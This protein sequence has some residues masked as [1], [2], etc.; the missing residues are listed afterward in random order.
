MGPAL[1]WV[2][3]IT[4]ASVILVGSTVLIGWALGNDALKGL[5]ADWVPMKANT[6]LAFVLAGLGLLLFRPPLS[7]RDSRR[8]TARM[9]TARIFTWLSGAIGLL[10]FAEHAFGWNAG[11]DQLIF[12]EPVGAVATSHPGRMSLDSAIC[13]V[14]LAVGVSIAQ[15]SRPSAKTR[16]ATAIAGAVISTIALGELFSYFSLTLRTESWGG[17]TQMAVDTAVLFTALGL[18]LLRVAVQVSAPES[19][20]PRSDEDRALDRGR[21]RILLVFVLLVVGIIAT[22]AAYYQN[23]ASRFRR[24]VEQQLYAVAELK[25]GE[26]K[27]WRT[28]RIAD[29]NILYRNPAITALVRRIF[30]GPD[31]ASARREL[32]MWLGKYGTYYRYDHIRLLDSAGVTRLSWPARIPSA[33]RVVVKQALEA[34]RSGQVAI[35]DFYRSDFDNTPRLAMLIPI[36]DEGARPRS[37]GV[38]VL[39]IDPSYYLYPLIKRWPT[40]SRTAE[41]LIV[42]REGNEVVFLNELR[43]QKNT[44]LAL[45]VPIDKRNI[46]LRFQ[47]DTALAL[48]VPMDKRNL[49]AVRAALGF[50]DVTTG[51]DYRGVAVIAAVHPVLDSPWSLVARMDESEAL[52]PLSAMFMQVAAAIG[53]LLLCAGVGLAV[54]SQR[55]QVRF[56][57]RQET[58]ADALRMEKATLDALFDSSPLALFVVDSGTNIVR[59]NLAA[60]TLTGSTASEMLHQRPGVALR[61]VHNT[62]D[63]RGC[64]YSHFCQLCPTRN[65]IERLI[66]SGG[67]MHGIEIPM[68]LIRDGTPQQVYLRTGAEAVMID[69]TR[70]LIIAMDDVTERALA[71]VQLRELTETLEERVTARTAALEA[72]N[73]EMEAFSYSVSH[74]LRAPLRS[75]DGFSRIVLADYQT[76]L[77]DEGRDSL[78]RIRAAAQHMA[79][80][81]DDMLT[82][83]RVSRAELRRERVDLSA[84]VR[85]VAADLTRMDPARAVEF[86]IPDGLVADGDPTLLRSVLDNLLGN[87]WKFTGRRAHARIEFGSVQQDGLTNYFVRDNGAGFDEAYAGKLFDAFQ[88]LHSRAEFPGTGIGLATVRRIIHRHGGRVW[89]HGAVDEG[90]TF[91]F[92]LND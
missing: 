6:A 90:A 54:Y 16:A 64:G 8:S 14:V 89:A 71:V 74:D 91:S 26:L 63:P 31:A 29:A 50:N 5:Y 67:S 53:V 7:T 28:E 21:Q 44:A 36:L 12:D 87:A 55:Q 9:L 58:L 76:K 25:V 77:D 38:I 15:R 42:R 1:D 39:R 61:C 17:F 56:Y 59:A 30:Q 57:Q 33:E 18:A 19:S 32:M 92:T 52:A 82:L 24:E 62:E 2:A 84:V 70:H 85:G 69:G 78:N 37:M 45:R 46:E 83:A 86:V 80:L 48:R 68:T 73:K 88:R 75:I 34:Y 49:P 23:S 13:F 81:I 66:M 60:E 10:S 4:S 40:P 22:G 3:P 47:K 43:F 79:K 72:A 20:A 41:T 65:G 51:I 11:I 27:Q 35:Q